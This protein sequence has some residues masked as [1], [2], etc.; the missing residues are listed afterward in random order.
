[1]TMEV[2]QE[3]EKRMVAEAETNPQVDILWHT[4]AFT[5]K[6]SYPLEILAQILNGRTGRL[7]KGM[8]LGSQIATD[9]GANQ[10]SKKWAGYFNISAEC[11][12]G[13]TPQQVEQGVYAELEKLQKDLVPAEELQKVKNQFAA[14][15]YRRLASNQ[16]ILFQ[17]IFADGLGHWAEVNEAGPKFQAVTAEDVKRVATTYFT[18]DN[19]CVASY[20]RKA[21]APGE[22]EDPDIAALAPEQKAMAK[23]LVSRLKA[24]TDAAKLRQG[25]ARM[26]Q[27]A[28]QAPAEMKTVLDL[29]KKKIQE[30][31]TEL[32]KK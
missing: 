27:N 25:L 17:L 12:E 29:V 26:E 7:Y 24:E 10:D 19:R 3:A 21:G 15:E 20:T 6:D 16:G 1:V 11:K 23:Q 28:A 32:E 13:H 30:R 31:I 4:V 22:A 14:A 8:V 2:K 9:A 5:H 18:K